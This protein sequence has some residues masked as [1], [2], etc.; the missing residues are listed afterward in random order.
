[1]LLKEENKIVLPL[2]VCLKDLFKDYNMYKFAMDLEL[3]S[4]MQRLSDR[5]IIGNKN[6]Y[7]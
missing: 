6:V 1:M 7:N 2:F 4:M 3:R 5:L